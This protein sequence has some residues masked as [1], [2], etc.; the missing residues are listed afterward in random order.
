MGFWRHPCYCTSSPFC[1]FWLEVGDESWQPDRQAWLFLSFVDQSR[2]AKP[3]LSY[4]GLN[5][6]QVP[7]AACMNAP[8][9]ENPHGYQ[10][11]KIQ[12]WYGKLLSRDWI[13]CSMRT[14]LPKQSWYPLVD[15]R[16]DDTLKSWRIIC[17]R[18]SVQVRAGFR[19]RTVLAENWAQPKDVFQVGNCFS[20]EGTATTDLE[21]SQIL[22][23]LIFGGFDDLMWFFWAFFI[24]PSQPLRKYYSQRDRYRAHVDV[25]YTANESLLVDFNEHFLLRSKTHVTVYVS[26]AWNV[27]S[28]NSKH[29]CQCMKG[30]RVS[31]CNVPIISE[32]KRMKRTHDATSSMSVRAWKLLSPHPPSQFNQTCFRDNVA[33]S[34]T[35][36]WNPKKQYV[37]YV[38]KRALCEYFLQKHWNL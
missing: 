14:S 2:A 8:F 34:M 36:L 21:T 20:L 11:S 13:W 37:G 29:V 23:G 32:C 16:L 10:K 15:W 38:Q 18:T 27:P 28:R 26:G 4:S 12:L 19:P 25:L 31:A 6:C 9:K 33:K 7:Y 22:G 24:R 5:W 35:M 30:M 3:E 17:L 1:F